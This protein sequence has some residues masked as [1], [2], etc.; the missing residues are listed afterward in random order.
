MLQ[1][2]LCHMLKCVKNPWWH[3]ATDSLAH[4]HQDKEA[5]R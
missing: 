2:R 5:S 1:T 4:N 3:D